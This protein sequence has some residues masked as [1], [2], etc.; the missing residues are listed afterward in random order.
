MRGVCKIS[1]FGRSRN[2]GDAHAAAVDIPPHVS[3]AAPELIDSNR[4]IY[5]P[6][7][8]VWS[9]GCIVFEMWT[10]RCPWDGNDAAAILLQ[11]RLISQATPYTLY[12]SADSSSQVYRT[13]QGPP[14]P[15]DIA[16]SHLAEDFR[17]KCFKMYVPLIGSHHDRD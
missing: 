13:Q 9:L 6:K 5:G 2:I 12:S 15:S 3:W 4:T 10:G 14:L 1:S 11:G 8:D 16:L 17:Q 7:A